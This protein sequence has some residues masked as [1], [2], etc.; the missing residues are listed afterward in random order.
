MNLTKSLVTFYFS[1]E[2]YH[3]V[4]KSETLING[5]ERFINSF[6]KNV[7]TNKQFKFNC[8]QQNFYFGFASTFLAELIMNRRS[9]QF[10]SIHLLRHLERKIR[11]HFEW[12]GFK[13]LNIIYESGTVSRIEYKDL[14]VITRIDNQTKTRDTPELSKTDNSQIFMKYHL[15]RACR[16]S[17]KK[18]EIGETYYETNRSA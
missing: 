12:I 4:S 10:G 3:N 13:D 11:S 15:N 14:E 1:A 9:H 5:Y 7:T 16:L 18:L 8:N 2:S 17:V 6:I